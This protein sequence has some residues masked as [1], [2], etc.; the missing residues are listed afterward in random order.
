MPL[1]NKKQP[2]ILSEESLA[3][4]NALAED[5]GPG[6]VTCR[7]LIEDKVNAVA[8]L[9]LKDRACVLCGLNVLREVFRQVD[10]RV[11]VSTKLKDGA[12]IKKGREVCIISGPAA[13]I[14]Q[15]ERTAL[16]FLSR[17][18][19]VATLTRGF[20][21][22][23]KNTRAK[24]LDTRKTTP[25]LRYLE[26]Y[27]VRTGGGSNHR[28]G[29]FDQVL[30]KDNHIAICL[31]HQKLSG[32]GEIVKKARKNTQNRV[33]IEIE[34]EKIKDLD[35]VLS[36]GPDIVMLD[37]MNAAQMRRAVKV[38]DARNKKIKLEASGNVTLSNVARIA[39]T[40]VDYI[41][42]GCLT[43]SAVN[44]DFSLRMKV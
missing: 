11:N 42:L 32:L 37:N 6:D 9:I 2:Q 12:R 17:L 20:A 33:I 43:H 23:V 25:G 40:G 41:S 27:A 30:I 10:P 28:F 19:A 26:K 3:V 4:T 34:I 14:L 24:I 21:D 29:L 22:K 36:A 16:N 35:D 39:R 7:A 5:I 8:R 38:R 44:I 1:K 15:G 31:K 13:S 18:S